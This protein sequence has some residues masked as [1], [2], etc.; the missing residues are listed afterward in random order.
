VEVN[1]KVSSIIVY[2][3]CYGTTKRYADELARRT[4]IKAVSYDQVQSLAEYDVIIHLGGL[5]AG[6]VWGLT[7]TVKLMQ[8]EGKQ[9]LIIGTV[10]LADPTNSENVENIRKSI[11]RQVPSGLYEQAQIFHLRGGIDY[12]KLNLKHRAMM[13]LLYAKVKRTPVEEQ[14][15]EVKAMI[16]TY[17]QVV[18]F[19]DFASLDEI[20]A[21]IA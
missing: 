20:V 1:S 6:G 3:T 10:G 4:G 2:G 11:R 18:D 13:S 5:Y 9:K 21:V 14:S 12:G 8:D 17:N 19:V 16:A 15:D 7:H